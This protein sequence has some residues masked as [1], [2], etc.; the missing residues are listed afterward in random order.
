MKHQD[1][2]YLDALAAQ[3]GI[4]L[5]R[6]FVGYVLDQSPRMLID[7]RI[8]LREDDYVRLLASAQLMKEL[9]DGLGATKASGYVT[10]IMTAYTV[11]DR[12]LALTLVAA[13]EQ[14]W[15][16]VL[17]ELEAWLNPLS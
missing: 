14:E 2:K 12:N 13:L 9:A 7:L 6:Q 16:H 11:K 3:M 8:S 5:A 1:S 17:A 4:N 15:K 10:E